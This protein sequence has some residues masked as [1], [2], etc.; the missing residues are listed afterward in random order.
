MEGNFRLQ[1]STNWLIRNR[2]RKSYR[3]SSIGDKMHS[4]L[5]N[6]LRHVIERKLHIIHQW[7]HV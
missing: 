2:I 1:S 4:L 5:K 3:S 7:K 6:K